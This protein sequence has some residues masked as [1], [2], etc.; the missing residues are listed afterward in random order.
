MGRRWERRRL[1]CS[2]GE[3]LG[4]AIMVLGLVAL[5]WALAAGAG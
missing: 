5:V 1:W 3:S 2:V 4:Y